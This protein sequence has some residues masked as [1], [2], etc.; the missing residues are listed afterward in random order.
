ML[1]LHIERQIEPRRCYRL[2]TV[3]RYKTKR[4]SA[5]ENQRLVEGVYA[6]LA[7][8]DP[9]GI[10]YATFRLDDGSFVHIFSTEADATSPSPLSTSP[11]FAEF[12]RNLAERC[13]EP[14]LAHEATLV[15]S[16]R[17]L[18]Y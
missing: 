10:R 3:I 14:P 8:R 11:A 18:A 2:T 15:G 5:D 12:Q 4:E 16:Y 1:V 7:T 17:L 13:V 9:G 6:E